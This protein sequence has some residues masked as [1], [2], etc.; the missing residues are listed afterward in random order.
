MKLLPRYMSSK[1]PHL[2]VRGL[3]IFQNVNLFDT[4]SNNLGLQSRLNNPLY[5]NYH[6]VANFAMVVVS[7]L[8]LLYAFQIYNKMQMGETKLVPVMTRFFLGLIVFLA[9]LSFLNHFAQKQDFNGNSVQNL[10]KPK[11]AK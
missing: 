5:N 1:V 11:L 3:F 10:N 8:F 7:I 4:P 9:S 6:I 2:G